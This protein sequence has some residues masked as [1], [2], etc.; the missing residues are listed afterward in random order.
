MRP[1]PVGSDEVEG[2]FVEVPALDAMLRGYRGRPP[3]D[4]RALADAVTR[5]SILAVRMGRRLG[6]LDLNPVIVGGVGAGATVVDARIIVEG[7]PVGAVEG[8]PVGA[9]KQPPGD[10]LAGSE[11]N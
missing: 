3:R 11:R 7:E 1:A 2:M 10:S 5:V 4:R 6:E 8:E 9:E